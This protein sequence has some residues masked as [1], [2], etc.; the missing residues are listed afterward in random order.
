ME[1]KSKKKII[2]EFESDLAG[3]EKEAKIPK[4]IIQEKLAKWFIRNTISAGLII[5]FWKYL[6]VQKS[7][8]VVVPL[9]LIS[10]GMILFYNYFVRKRL[11][12]AQ[13]SIEKLEEVFEKKEEEPG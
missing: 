11:A 4:E 2:T 7:L 8:F 10:L 1:E 3:I 9:S 12:S 5:Y 13:K 6:W